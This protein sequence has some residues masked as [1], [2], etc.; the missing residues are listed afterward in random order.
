ML[1]ELETILVS[2]RVP[3]S[4][5]SNEKRQS[6]RK[7]S[8]N[9]FNQHVIISLTDVDRSNVTTVN[10]RVPL[11][12]TWHVREIERNDLL[13]STSSRESSLNGLE[14]NNGEGN[15]PINFPDELPSFGKRN[16]ITIDKTRSTNLITKTRFHV[17][18]AVFKLKQS[19]HSEV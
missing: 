2:R 3:Y 4:T 5:L 7:L 11:A 14:Q 19:F 15:N 1:D 18:K 17:H 13:P 16:Q 8:V 9:A 6:T 12:G 10:E